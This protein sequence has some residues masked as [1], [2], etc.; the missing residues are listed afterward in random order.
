MYSHQ[1]KGPKI[2]QEREKSKMYAPHNCVYRHYLHLIDIVSVIYKNL[3]Q[4]LATNC[5]LIV[6]F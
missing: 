1:A 3:K 2:A 5:G 4:D 6:T